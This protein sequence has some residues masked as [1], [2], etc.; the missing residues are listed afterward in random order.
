MLRVAPWKSL[1]LT[2]RWLS[3][4]LSRELPALPP[5]HM[6]ICYGCVISKKLTKDDCC[7]ETQQLQQHYCCCCN[8]TIDEQP[9]VCLKSTCSST[10]HLFCLSKRFLK[11]GE[12][13]PI[14]GDCPKCGEIFL[15]GDLIRKYKGCYGNMDITVNCIEIFDSDSE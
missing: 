14:D 7:E 10:S 15:W 1:P 3:E 13:I 11:C 8:E 2:I 6:P 5:I 12:Y 4:D 9:L